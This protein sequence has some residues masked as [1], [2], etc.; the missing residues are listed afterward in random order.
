MKK[1]PL[2]FLNIQSTSAG[3]K[4][5]KETQTTQKRSMDETSTLIEIPELSFDYGEQFNLIPC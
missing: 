1:S 5:W 4:T 2:L 3:E